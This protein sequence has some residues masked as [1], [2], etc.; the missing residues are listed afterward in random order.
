[1]KRHRVV[2]V[3]IVWTFAG[4]AASEGGAQVAGR[5]TGRSDSDLVPTRLRES[6]RRLWLSSAS[7]VLALLCLV[8]TIALRPTESRA[9]VVALVRPWRLAFPPPPPPMRIEGVG[10]PVMRGERARVRV[11]AQERRIVRLYW[12]A[13]GEAVRSAGVSVDEVR[14]SAEG[15][16]GL[17]HVPMDVWAED[18]EGRSSDTLVVR[19][20]DPLLAAELQ[21]VVLSPAWAGGKADTLN[22]PIPS[23][24]VEPGT[25]LQ[26]SGRT[27]HPLGA[28]SLV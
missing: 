24:T 8:S 19:P 3:F 11:Q 17:V 5:L 21:V 4:C 14:G 9:A 25:T 26:V 18:L 20:V 12:R 27:N 13:E 23:L 16:T 10:G 15:E 6:R 7:S 22:S 2:Q 1:M 28:G